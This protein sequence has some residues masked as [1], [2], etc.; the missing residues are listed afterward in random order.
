METINQQSSQEELR[1]LVIVS[2]YLSNGVLVFVARQN[3]HKD[4]ARLQK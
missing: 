3:F 4:I 1:Q 2:H